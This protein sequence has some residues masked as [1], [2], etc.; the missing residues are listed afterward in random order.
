MQSSDP[1]LANPLLDPFLHTT[2]TTNNTDMQVDKKGSQGESLST[3]AILHRPMPLLLS[4]DTD[5]YMQEPLMLDKPSP[6][7]NHLSF[8]VAR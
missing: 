2:R 8:P 5:A 7:S 6:V 3:G 1:I 4:R